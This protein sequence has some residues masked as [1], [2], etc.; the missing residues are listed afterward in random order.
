MFVSKNKSVTPAQFRRRVKPCLD[1]LDRRA[2]STEQASQR[3]PAYHAIGRLVLEL[4]PDKPKYGDRL[5]E[6][7][8]EATG[9]GTPW[10]LATQRFARRYT[11]RELGQLSKHAGSLHWGH[12]VLLLGVQN[13][14]TRLNWQERAAK[15][16]WSPVA[17]R[18]QIRKTTPKR[19]KGG[20]P[21]HGSKGPQACLKQLTSMTHTCLAYH[22]QLCAGEDSVLAGLGGLPL[23]KLTKRLGKEVGV[24]RQT[25]KELEK[26]C[27][28]T[29][30]QL[31]RIEKQIDQKNSS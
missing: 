29:A 19:N 1:I 15:H 24:A 27:R 23:S 28:E 16:G 10:L 14:K 21:L 25:L 5:F 22:Q 12:L 31:R 30:G 2:V 6:Q 11:K 8:A 7:L 20:R 9:R 17:L 3:L 4:V 13:K 26:A 18:E